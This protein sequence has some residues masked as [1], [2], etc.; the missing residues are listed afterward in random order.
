[1]TT[2]RK[3]IDEILN[4]PGFG[5]F[6]TDHMITANW[7]DRH[8]WHEPQLQSYQ[9]LVLDPATLALQYGQEI[10]EGL[11]AYR[12]KD[13]RIVCFR[14][15]MNAARFAR[16]AKRL[17]MAEVPELM[18]IDA[19]KMLVTA[20]Q[21]WVPNGPEKTLYLRPFM[22]G[23]EVG[24]GVRPSN[25]YLFVVIASPAGSYFPRG[26]MPVK[27][28]LSHDYVRAAPGGT[29][30][31]KCAGNY[32]ASLVAQAEA[33]EHGC[34]Q[35]VWLD[36]VERRWVEEMG[37]MNLF[38]VYGQGPE[39]RLV[40]PKLT[41]TLLP[42]VTRDSLLT[43][44]TDRGY[45]VTEDAISVEQ[46]QAGCK[47]G[48]ITE[49]FAC[50]TAAV[51]TPIGEVFSNRTGWKIGDGHPGPVTQDLRSALLDIQTGV[52]SDTHGWLTTLVDN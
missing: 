22:L 49:V 45:E 20:D 28:W 26:I 47:S 7:E 10:F 44:A 16:S 38:F 41:G 52:T 12:H 33:I 37:G 31:A 13:G 3:R 9:P 51:I 19:L 17:A 27:V 21:E 43:L 39:A 35:V 6:F 36:A 8:G 34:D 11:K 40:T 24:L 48:E 14:P 25:N 5:R 30:E 29:G 42:G 32:A 50:G 1:M 2:S 18:F 23:S 46:W 4:D 15:N